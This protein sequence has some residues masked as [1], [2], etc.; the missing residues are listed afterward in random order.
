M[1]HAYLQMVMGFREKGRLESTSLLFTY[2]NFAKYFVKSSLP[3]L[4]VFVIGNHVLTS[5]D[6]TNISQL[7]RT[8]E[9]FKSTGT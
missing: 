1:T 7:L 4:V 6:L 5:Y 3:G 8:S 9:L 2:S